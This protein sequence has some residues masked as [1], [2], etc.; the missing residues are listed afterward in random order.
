MAANDSDRQ[1]RWFFLS[2]QRQPPPGAWTDNRLAQS[3]HYTGV[4]YLALNAVVEAMAAA[5]VWVE[6]RLER[7]AYT[8]AGSAGDD[9][10]YTPIDPSHPLADIVARPNPQETFPSLLSYMAL[11]WGLTGN[12]P[13][14]F[15]PGAKHGRPVELYALPEAVMQPLLSPGVSDYPQ[16]AWLV[17]PYYPSG[18]AWAWGSMA[19]MFSRRVIL[20]AEEVHKLQ[21][22]HPLLRNDGYSPLTA[23]GVQFDIMEAIDRSRHAAM[24]YSA[25]IG[26]VVKLPAGYSQEQLEAMK[27]RWETEYAGP[28]RARTALIISPPVE[29][30]IQIEP[31]GESPRE[32][33]YASS[34]EQAAKFVLATFGVPP[35]VAGLTAATGYAEFYAAQVQLHYRLSQLARRMADFFTLHLAGPWSD[36]PGQYRVKIELPRPRNQDEYKSQLLQLAAQGAVT[37]NELRAAFDL[38]PLPG[39]DVPPVIYQQRF[40]GNAD[41]TP[42]V[43][44]DKTPI[45]NADDT[46][47]GSA[48]SYPEAPAGAGARPPVSKAAP[49]DIVETATGRYRLDRAKDGRLVPHKIADKPLHPKARP[50]PNS[51]HGW[52]AVSSSAISHVHYDQQHQRLTVRFRGTD[53]RFITYSGITPEMMAELSKRKS[54]GKWLNEALRHNPRHEWTLAEIDHLLDPAI[55]PPRIRLV[56]NEAKGKSDKDLSQTLAQLIVPPRKWSRGYAQQACAAILKSLPA[57]ARGRPLF[58]QKYGAAAEVLFAVSMDRGYVHHGGTAPADVSSGPTTYRTSDGYEVVLGLDLKTHSGEDTVGRFQLDGASLHRKADWIAWDPQVD[59]DDEFVQAGLARKHRVL[60]HFAGLDMRGQG[61]KKYGFAYFVA[62]SKEGTS[63]GRCKAGENGV[64]FRV[65]RG[66][67]QV[68]DTY[69]PAGTVLRYKS[70]EELPPEIILAANVRQWKQWG[71]DPAKHALPVKIRGLHSAEDIMANPQYMHE[72]VHQMLQKYLAAMNYEEYRRYV[73]VNLR[74]A[75]NELE[76][77][78]EAMALTSQK[79]GLEEDDGENNL[80]RVAALERRKREQLQR[81]LKR[82]VEKLKELQQRRNVVHADDHERVVKQNKRLKDRAKQAEEARKQAEYHLNAQQVLQQRALKLGQKDPAAAMQVLQH[83]AN[84]EYEQADALL[85][86]YRL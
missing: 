30:E 33:D 71:F 46:P 47:T 43:G 37:V 34:W 6:Q 31:L 65:G 68:G 38:V 85:A 9:E 81:R 82:E 48:P 74:K 51:P 60:L 2:G 27:R 13:V 54:L 24:L 10:D 18:F 12:A 41:D 49:G 19:A 35:A 52:H 64:E 29:G 42:T 11:Q 22:P 14:W 4:I 28:E 21:A 77:R 59:G 61:N 57:D 15:V 17:M 1:A 53:D 84:K 7:K 36:Y 44:A 69:H 75:A 25:Q 56:L 5:I 50:L 78:K 79:L 39:G 83:I 23:C 8:G 20:P 62:L 80:V 86:K 66:G 72:Q 45:N 32:M 70:G 26:Q 3:Q 73:G 58:G 63:Y 55:T 67:L 40:A 16:G 76:V